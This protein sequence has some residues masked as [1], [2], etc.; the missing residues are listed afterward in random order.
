MVPKLYA[1]DR[2]ETL[3]RR[4]AAPL[5]FWRL[6]FSPLVVATTAVSTGILK[7]FGIVPIPYADVGTPQELRRL[8]AESYAGG[9]LEAGEAGMLSGVF[10]LHEQEAR[11][12][13]TPIPAVVTVDVSETVG[14]A[15]RRCVSTGHS[16]L[17]VTERFNLDRV[18]GIVHVNQLVRLMISSGEGASF[19]GLVR[20]APIVPETK[21]L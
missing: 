5:Q 8:I 9:A 2:A 12:V 21:P 1:I 20:P 17:L 18:L 14:D 6:L 7:L 16:R 19:A 13:M 3:A 15:L 10:H 11:Q 4:L